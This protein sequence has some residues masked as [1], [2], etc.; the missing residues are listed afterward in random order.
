MKY[1]RKYL[2][3]TLR[4]L[5]VLILISV[6]SIS[7]LV[8]RVAFALTAKQCDQSYLRNI[9]AVNL[10]CAIEAQCSLPDSTVS[11]NLSGNDNPEK[12]WNFFIQ[13]G[14]SP[15]NAAGFLGNIQ[16][17]SGFNPKLVE[18]AFSKKPHLSDT[19]PP[20]Q[21]KLGQPGYG[22]IQWT[23]PTRRDKLQQKVDTD[24]QKRIA[25]DISLQLEL[26]WE[27]LNGG[28]KKST[29]D[30]LRNAKTATESSIIITKNYEI[31]GDLAKQTPKRAAAAEE[32]LKK[33]SSLSQGVPIPG[34]A[35]ATP[36]TSPQCGTGISGPGENTKF[37]DGFTVYSQYDP[38]W[39]NAPYSSSTIGKSGCG[40]A[41][42]AMIITTLTGKSVKPP[43]TANFAASKGIY[44]PGAGS[45]WNIAPVLAQNWGLKATPIGKDLSKI[46]QTLQAGG[47]VI[48]SGKGP[49]P[50]TTGG[51]YIVIRAVTASGKFLVGDSA[52]EAANTKEW[53]PQQILSA[54]PG[55]ST[56]A[57]T[58]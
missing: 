20:A 51:H 52:H 13:K 23:F 37:I 36:S 8:P 1:Y 48:A 29:L 57:I 42:M 34:G 10:S 16:A 28:F 46:T 7:V 58:K 21:N 50:F 44:V 12:I 14:L 19:L 9:G 22:L 54:M 33:Y 25:G 26:I 41:A 2:L 45:G 15:Q 49:V 40:P 4:I 56:Y 39:K 3:N 53:E 31:P 38:T 35:P 32:F 43:E 30:P 47:L 17:E 6:L 24:P 18:Y 11:I 5:K 55:G 27:E